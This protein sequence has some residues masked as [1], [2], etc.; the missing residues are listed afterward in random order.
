MILDY[1]S[2]IWVHGVGRDTKY[3]TFL[4]FSVSNRCN[5]KCAMCDIWRYKST[6]VSTQLLSIAFENSYL[7]NIEAFGITGGEPF[8]RPDLP[9]ILSLITDRFKR[10]KYVGITTNGFNT[11][12]INRM[13]E[14]AKETIVRI[15]EFGITVSVDGLGETHDIS[16]GVPRV[17]K[18]VEETIK[19]LNE[20][21]R[22]LVT[23]SFA[24]TITNL[25]ASAEELVKLHDYAN[26]LGVPV[27]YRIAVCVDRIFNKEL[28][29]KHGIIPGTEEAKEVIQ[30][31]DDKVLKKLTART[32]YYHMVRDYLSGRIAQR[33]IK[34]KEMR[35]GLMVD[36]NGDVYVCSVSGK[37][38]GN[39]LSDSEEVLVEKSYRARSDVRCSSCKKC[40][41]DHLS[42][43]APGQILVSAI[44]VMGNK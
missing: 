3:P 40:Y 12:R 35:D 22:E 26:E 20:R 8:V 38:I 27:I 10:V 43:K 34:C 4:N 42:H 6:D 32:T 1:F 15:P 36:S 18:K 13:L 11:S 16:R 25:N 30:F 5:A 9:D 31:L 23:L 14:E 44:R 19:L 21:H 37:K 7:R 2:D 17:W 28:I 24:C 41:H 39:L 29:D 33:S